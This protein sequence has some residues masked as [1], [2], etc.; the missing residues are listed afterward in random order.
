MEWLER[1]LVF[2][3]SGVLEGTPA[4]VGG[5][6]YEDAEM[7]TPDGVKLHGW[8]VRAPD[9]KAR[10]LFFHGN[11]GNISHRRHHLP[12]FTRRGISALY[13]DYRGYGQS[14]GVPSELGLYADAEAALD[15][16]KKQP[17]QTVPI[18]YYGESLG[19]AV[20][21]ELAAEVEAPYKIILEGGFTSARDMAKM[22]YSFL[23]SAFPLTYRFDSLA[24]ISKIKRPLLSIHGTED[25]IVPFDLG[26][27]LFDAHPGPKEFYAVKGAEHNNLVEVAGHEFYDRIAEFISRDFSAA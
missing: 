14:K 21:V 15:W 20:A 10:I 22:M 13:V 18:V 12:E 27:V 23:G 4:D 24:K 6:A 3:P 2:F 16:L 11:A 19:S 7:V 26:K 25:D 8:F 1:Q 17:P 5:L 9:E